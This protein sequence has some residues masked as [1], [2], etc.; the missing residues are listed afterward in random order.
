MRTK[1]QVRDWMQERAREPRPLPSQAQMNRELGRPLEDAR[2][3]EQEE[4]ERRHGRWAK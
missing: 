4:L 1:E 2:R 3:L